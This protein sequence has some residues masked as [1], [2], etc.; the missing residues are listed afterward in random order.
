V[1]IPRQPLL[2][3]VSGALLLIGVGIVI[4][5]YAKTRYW[6]DL[7]LLLSIPL[8]MLPSILSLAFPE[9]NPAPNRAGGA[10]IPVFTVAGIALVSVISGLRAAWGRRS[11]VVVA[12]ATVALLLALA[13]LGNYR[14]LFGDYASGYRTRSWNTKDAGT[15]I[16]G[17][18]DSIGTTATAHVIPYPHWL[19]TRLVGFQAGTP[20]VD[21]ALPPDAIESL[22]GELGPQLFLVNLLDVDTMT[23]LRQTFPGGVAQTFL[24]GIEGRDFWIYFV[25]AR[26]VAQ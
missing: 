10:L 5:R 13:G 8:L 9:E 14:M 22:T 15:V 16:R 26:G 1:T 12:T 4:A 6:A 24:S 18:A 25:P 3:I 7:F 17:F 11:G 19:D 2:D 20:G 21:Y 23:R